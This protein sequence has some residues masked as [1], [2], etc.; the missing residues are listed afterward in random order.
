[1]KKLVLATLLA[2]VCLQSSLPNEE[3]VSCLELPVEMPAPGFDEKLHS[4]FH[5]AWEKTLYLGAGAVL[6]S[7]SILARLGWGLCLAS[8][9]A[10]TM[11]NECLLLSDVLGC[12]AHHL[13]LYVGKSAS[14]PAVK[15]APLSHQSWYLNQM[16][17]SQIPAFSEQEKQL[18]H[19]L[20]KR[21]LAKS[22]GFY[23]AMV[24]WFCPCFG[25]I[26][27]VDPDTDSFY[28]RD[29][30]NKL[31][32]VYSKR[33]GAWKQLLPQ[34]ESYPLLL[35]RPFDLREHLP[36]YVDIDVNEQVLL[37]IARA[38]ENRKKSDTPILID[39]TKI[40]PDKISD[41]A[42]WLTIWENYQPAFLQAC[43][44]CSITS[45]Q[46][47]CIQRVE[48]EEI[49]GIRV[50][51]FNDQSPE[52][53]ERQYRFLLE[54]V[55]LFGL[56]A[57]RIELDRWS[58]ASITPTPISK[59]VSLPLTSPSKEGFLSY[60]RSFD[61]Q[62][63]SEHPQKTLMFT[64]TLRILQGLLANLPE[65]RWTQIANSPTK[66]SL[67]RLAFAKIQKRLEFLAQ[68]DASS[69]FF[70]T[71]SHIE[72]IHADLSS[73]LEIL[74]P[75]TF[76][77]F[78]AIYQSLLLRIPSELQPLTSCGIH[79]SGMT[80]LGGIFKALEKNLGRP[81]RILYGENAYFENIR[82][83]HLIAMAS[84]IDEAKEADW[85][86]VDLILAQFNPALKRIN[87]DI[88]IYRI[89]KIAE[90][91]HTC[92]AAQRKKPLT[93]AID[94]TF[95]FI[96]SPQVGH[97]LEEFQNEIEQGV[98]N[99][100]CYRSGLKLDLF[101]M[102]NY[103]GAPFFMVHN[104]DAQWS[105]F[106]SVLNDPVLQADRLSLNWFCAAYQYAAPQL[107]LYRKQI[108][109]NTQSLL[110]KVP[111]R[112]LHDET[113]RY[114]IIPMEKEGNLAFIDIKVFGPLHQLRASFLVGGGLTTKCM[115][116]GHPIFYRTS[117]GFYHP[118]FTVLY[119]EKCSTIRLTL[120]L[121]PE[122]VDLLA[123]FF[124]RIDSLNG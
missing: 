33:M 7:A 64:A 43:K 6:G 52:R 69:P 77:N 106:D 124:I 70:E 121:D 51:P 41:R 9:W 59:R 60:L 45:D 17:L 57:T 81:P 78:S 100:I 19:F 5:N 113:A 73:L 50:L 88:S 35:T 122:Q 18:L 79:A 111:Q 67:A 21:W 104:C 36:S 86:E 46:V 109:E 80:S 115:P 53:I 56:S 3:V 99:V 102:D 87:F 101:G 95:D 107:E 8:P 94:C 25:V 26:V 83:A 120:G 2:T 103:C 24:N 84:S 14:A 92:F 105:S 29:P 116:S 15:Q 82:A 49:G 44:E 10:S 31:S 66:S 63:R 98:L 65:N 74:S 48:Q 22:S 28:A 20:E 37:I 96:D 117:V 34:P 71:V 23:S 76:E 118:N 47:L 110:N 11:G 61:Q 68:N 93:V 90:I 55:S 27:Q 123:D 72:Q 97:L 75:F 40:F 112:L 39:V 54:W 119:G 16:L 1:V 32:P 42:Q 114:R 62:W 91:L 85:Q 30:G 12:T 89:E 108:F 13:F 58:C 4:F 38:L